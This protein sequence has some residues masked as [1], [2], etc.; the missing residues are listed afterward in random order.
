MRDEPCDR[1]GN[2]TRSR[3]AELQG[4]MD[5]TAPPTGF[6]HQDTVDED[7]SP[8]L[9]AVL[10]A[11]IPG[12]GHVHAGL[13]RRGLY[14]FGVWLFYL[15]VTSILVVFGIGVLLALALPLVHFVVA[16]DAYR[17]V[18]RWRGEERPRLG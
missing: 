3:V 16:G 9:A 7:E 8:L 17:Q 15:F 11:V 14:W 13:R 18:G 4:S 12:A 5:P 6:G 2:G 1:S 10:S